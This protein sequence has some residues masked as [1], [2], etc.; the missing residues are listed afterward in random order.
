MED[1]Q[2]V[3]VCGRAGTLCFGKSSFFDLKIAN[4]TDLSS[5]SCSSLR[6]PFFALCFLTFHWAESDLW[7]SHCSKNYPILI[8]C[9]PENAFF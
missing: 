7:Q 6:E 8:F 1:L 4:V 9:V 5:R 3:P 2:I